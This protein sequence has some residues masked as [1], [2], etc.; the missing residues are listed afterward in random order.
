M[1]TFEGT[2]EALGPSVENGGMRYGYIRIRKDDGRIE[3]IPNIIAFT[4]VDAELRHIIDS[5]DRRITL[6]TKG[7]T[8]IYAL[9][10]DGNLVSDYKSIFSGWLFL[11]FKTFGFLG[12]AILLLM[13]GDKSMGVGGIVFGLAGM[14]MF[15]QNIGST[16]TLWPDF[17]AGNLTPRN[18]TQPKVQSAA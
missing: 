14:I 1:R 12:I 17:S 10:H 15:L 6:Y 3:N 2:L 7:Y 9:E 8:Y 13:S 4:N 11:M 16:T 5:D 18:P